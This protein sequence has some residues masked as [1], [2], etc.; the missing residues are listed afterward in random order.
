MYTVLLL[1]I[2][3]TTCINF[4]KTVKA[5]YRPLPQKAVFFSVPH[6]GGC[7][8]SWHGSFSQTPGEVITEARGQRGAFQKQSLGPL[9]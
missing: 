7:E 6:R 1:I 8:D 3:K 9:D 2:V 5:M 4:E